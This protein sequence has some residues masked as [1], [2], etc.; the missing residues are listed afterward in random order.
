MKKI[1]Q[2]KDA[3]A[4][5]DF[6]SIQNIRLEMGASKKVLKRTNDSVVEE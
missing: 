5:M 2:G 1:T 6:I 4:K 3:N